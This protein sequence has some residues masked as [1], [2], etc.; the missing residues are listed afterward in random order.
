MLRVASARY[1]ISSHRT[2]IALICYMNVSYV[3]DAEFLGYIDSGTEE[4]RGEG[5]RFHDGSRRKR[6]FGHSDRYD[7]AH[8]ASS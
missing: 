3:R 8:E 5:T 7:P 1:S 6:L 4:R 2:V